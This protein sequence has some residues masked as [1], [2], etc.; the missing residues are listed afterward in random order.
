MND[1]EYDAEKKLF[2]Y[3]PLFDWSLE[4]VENYIKEKN[5]PY[6]SLYDKGYLS[7]G[8]EPC[9]RAVLKGNDFRSGRWWW[10]NEG[11]KEC[12]CHIK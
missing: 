3:H 6:N 8:C 10:E 1:I 4:D 12:G 7:I 5:I 2:N 9:T 11:Q